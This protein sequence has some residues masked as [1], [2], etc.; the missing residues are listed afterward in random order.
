MIRKLSTRKT[1]TILFL[2][3]A[4]ILVTAGTAL[5]A[6]PAQELAPCTG[7]S[8]S[9]TVIAVDSETNTATISTS[10]G[11]CTVTM[12]KTSDHPIVALLGWY[13]G[14]IK[15]DSFDASLEDVKGCAVVDA[16]GA[17]AWAACDAEG[18]VPVQVVGQNE[19]GTFIAVGADGQAIS[20]TVDEA[21]A[22]GISDALAGLAVDWQ[23]DESGD[24]VQVSDQIAAYHEEGMGFGVLVKLYSMADKINTACEDVT[25]AEGEACGASVDELVTEFNSGA[26]MGQMF[27]KYGKPNK[28][29][30]G[31]IKQ[32][33][34]KGEE[35]VVT[36][37]V[38][39]EP[40]T[41][42]EL[43][44]EG[45]SANGNN[46]NGNGQDKDKTNNGNGNN[47]VKPPK[48]PKPPKK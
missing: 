8:V 9:G 39:V 3:L 47:K 33:Q 37:E 10:T 20:V 38:T 30:V 43:L 14:D 24:V 35:P 48:P 17:Y 31:H 27:E 7:E 16:T 15:T 22:G 26:G 1:K 25:L 41:E 19:D 6:S 45:Q 11:M 5:A 36:P 21:S 32:E 18:A 23:I 44:L 42:G 4:L 40:G 29:G 46:G 12:E 34:K 2:V 28:I 13:F